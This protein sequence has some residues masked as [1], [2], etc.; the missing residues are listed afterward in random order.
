[1]VDQ[2]KKKYFD[3]SLHGLPL[4]PAPVPQKEVNQDL[5]VKMEPMDVL[6]RNLIHFIDWV[7]QLSRNDNSYHNCT[8]ECY[9]VCN[10]EHI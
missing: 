6:E 9:L 3:L 5:D 7:D 8:F 1:M 10:S 2:L 4:N